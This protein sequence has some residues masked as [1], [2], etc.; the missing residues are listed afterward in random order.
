LV[1]CLCGEERLVQKTHKL[2][3]TYFENRGAAFQA[4]PGRHDMIRIGLISDTHNLLRPEARLALAGVDHIIH[5]GDICGDAVL[6][7]LAQ[8]APVVAVRGNNDR[9]AWT[10]SLPEQETVELGG[11]K[12]HVVHDLHDLEPA[13]EASGIQ[14]VVTGHSHRPA[15]KKERGVLYVNP[16][17][18]GPRRFKL[19]ISLGFLEIDDGVPKASL[20]T[21]EVD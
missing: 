18:A 12:I 17:S 11:V 1:E 15:V 16:G 6:A 8:I 2:I 13:P 21:L 7:Q 4:S 14:V 20:Q 9:G 3:K 19:P 10:Q 5:A